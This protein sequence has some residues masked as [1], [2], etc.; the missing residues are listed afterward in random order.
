MGIMLY[1]LECI[2]AW[3][4]KENAVVINDIVEDGLSIY[5]PIFFRGKFFLAG[6]VSIPQR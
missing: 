5:A 6:L 3:K 4:F 2:I 1:S